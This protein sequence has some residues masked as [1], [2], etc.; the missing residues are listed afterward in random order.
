[1]HGRC[2]YTGCE[3]PKRSEITEAGNEKMADVK[4]VLRMVG[5][6]LLAVFVLSVTIPL[7]FKAVGL[8]FA[9]LG[10]LVWLA[11]QLI[12][13]VVVI[14]IAYLLLVGIRALLR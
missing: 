8:T 12:Y 13:I 9:I 2:S 3:R 5:M 14:A 7:V 10:F 6:V 4:S 1:M 11:M